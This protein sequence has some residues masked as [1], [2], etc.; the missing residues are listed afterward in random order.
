MNNLESGKVNLN[1]IA[2]K[3]NVSNRTVYRQLKAE[4]ISYKALLNDV[5]KQLA[6]TYLKEASISINDISFLLGFSEA[7][8][9]HRAFKRWFGMNPGRYRRKS[10]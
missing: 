1:M 7:S 2:E 8:A 3:L 9:F 6:Q 5:Q 10:G 4:N